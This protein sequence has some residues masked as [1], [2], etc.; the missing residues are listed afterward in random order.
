VVNAGEPAEAALMVHAG[1]R[2]DQRVVS[3]LLTVNGNELTVAE[4][5]VPVQLITDGH[6]ASVIYTAE[7]ELMAP[8]IGPLSFADR[9][10]WQY[11]SRYCPVDSVAGYART[12][13]GVAGS[14][15]I[16]DVAEFVNKRIEYITGSSD[17]ATNAIDTL[18]G[19]AGVCR[20]FAHLTIALL[21]ALFVPARYVAAYVPGVEPPDFHALVE[22]HDGERW[23]LLDPTGLSDPTYAVRIAHGRDGAD[24]AFL[25]TLSGQLSIRET[26]VSAVCA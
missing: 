1:N 15:T 13:F 2:A 16:M 26:T 12:E 4:G 24:V 9:V 14:D 3:D 18:V 6:Q 7:V 8:P 21:R 25:T 23:Q 5:G 11:P 17:T 19:G 20:D 10:G 22:A